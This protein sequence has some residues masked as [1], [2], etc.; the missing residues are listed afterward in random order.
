MK[1]CKG[2]ACDV[3]LLKK[4]ISEKKT[5][6]EIAEIMEVTAPTLKRWIVKYG[7]SGKREAGRKA[8]KL[9]SGHN[10]DRHLCETCR[11]QHKD[12]KGCDYIIIT[13]KPRGCDPAECCVYEKE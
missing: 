2:K 8:K 5:N 12:G 10:A 3:E 6:K 7:L 11:F 13:G 1:K 4:L 9:G